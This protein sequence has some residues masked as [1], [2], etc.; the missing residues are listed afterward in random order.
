MTPFTAVFNLTGQPAVTVPLGV[1]GDGLP[2]AV[3]LVGRLGAEDVLYSLAG[4]LERAAPWA[5]R[6]PVVLVARRRSA[7]DICRDAAA[8]RRVALVAAGRGAGGCSR[9]GD[10]ASAGA[11]TVW[12]CQP[13]PRTTRARP[14][15]RRPSTRR[16]CSRCG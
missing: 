7:N 3:Q 6:R 14:D 1:D 4:Q 13:G 5:Q 2:T 15:C 12:L 10:A 8:S 9:C 16:R 11:K